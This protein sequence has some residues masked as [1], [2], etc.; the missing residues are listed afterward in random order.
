MNYIKFFF[1]FFLL[2]VVLVGCGTQYYG[3]SLSDNGSIILSSGD[4]VEVIADAS[5]V[6]LVYYAPSVYDSFSSNPSYKQK[7]H[8]EAYA[9]IGHILEN[10][11]RMKKT[12]ASFESLSS[13]CEI[14]FIFYDNGVLDV[15]VTRSGELYLL[16]GSEVYVSDK[17]AVDPTPYVKYMN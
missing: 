3:L 6:S 7:H 4:E 2:V 15:Y 12:D 5:S 11:L 17:N 10:E 16:N 14:R 13:G 9:V 8:S 1:C